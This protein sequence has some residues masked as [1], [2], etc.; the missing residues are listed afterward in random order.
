MSSSLGF[1]REIKFVKPIPAIKSSTRG[2]KVQRYR[3][4]GD[5][6]LV[7]CSSTRLEN[8]P[9]ADAF[10]VEDMIAVSDQRMPSSPI[11]IQTVQIDSLA[12]EFMIYG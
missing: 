1:G 2:V 7:I 5:Y 3:R 8:V 4:F 12:E 6:G 10:S 9:G 11:Q